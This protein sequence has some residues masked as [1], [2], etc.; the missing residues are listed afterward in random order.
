MNGINKPL[1][2]KDYQIVKSF[3]QLY[4]Y[5]RNLRRSIQDEEFILRMNETKLETVGD[6]LKF[7]GKIFLHGLDYSNYYN[8]KIDKKYDYISEIDGIDIYQ[9]CYINTDD[10]NEIKKEE[11]D[12]IIIFYNICLKIDMEPNKDNI[13]YIG[14]N[15][16]DFTK[17]ITNI[18]NGEGINFIIQDP[19][20]K[21]TNLFKD[22]ILSYR[23][24]NEYKKQFDILQ[25]Y[26]KIKHIPKI[27]NIEF[28]NKSCEYKI[29]NFDIDTIDTIINND[30]LSVYI[31]FVR[32]N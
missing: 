7:Y 22:L 24:N 1:L 21:I 11:Q 28:Y 30:F 25:N 12:N 20:E 19:D 27:H 10:F 15:I 6:Y 14:V 32:K 16:K 18:N 8:R 2:K 17:R 4:N 23:I 29:D 26:I 3:R 5:I 13:K 9:Y 31:Y